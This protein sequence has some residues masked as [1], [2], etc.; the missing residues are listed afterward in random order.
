MPMDHLTGEKAVRESPATMVNF[1]LAARLKH[2]SHAC[3][4]HIKFAMSIFMDPDLY[5]SNR[6]FGKNVIGEYLVVLV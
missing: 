5:C 3:H 6:A 4:Q 1:Q 2:W